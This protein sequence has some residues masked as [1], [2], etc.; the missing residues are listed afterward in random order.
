MSRVRLLLACV[1]GVATV[2]LAPLRAVGADDPQTD[3]KPDPG[4]S[5]TQLQGFTVVA[6]KKLNLKAVPI[7]VLRDFVKAHGAPTHIG[8]L[9]RWI[10][11]VCPTT[12]GLSPEFNAFI[13]QRVNAVAAS[14]GAPV[15]LIGPC[16]A[17]IQI[18]FTTE[19]QQLLDSLREKSPALLGYHYPSQA[20]RIATVT[21]PIQ[22]W[23]ATATEGLAAPSG[24]LAAGGHQADA[25]FQ[26][27]LANRVGGGLALDAPS[28]QP[29]G[30]V[31]GGHFGSRLESEFAVITIVGDA[32]K[33]AGYKIDSIAD[34][35]ALLALSQTEALDDCGSLLSITN[36]MSTA[37]DAASRPEAMT[38]GD[39]AY[40]KALYATD[41]SNKLW[42]QQGDIVDRMKDADAKR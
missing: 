24:A 31:A 12:V 2:A 19:P 18:I 6:P 22:A 25:S 37:C 28:G 32:N 34:Y 42:V 33:A 30:G 9:A 36:L 7:P 17:N 8:Q 29:P 20:K 4:A 3:Q 10:D 40:L 21:H 14:V 11:D 16:D 26:R 15:K 39:L 23:Y 5:S 13:A 35:I 1:I 27:Y 38:D 41:L